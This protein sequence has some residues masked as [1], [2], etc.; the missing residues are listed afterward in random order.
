MDAPPEIEGTAA[1]KKSATASST[2]TAELLPGLRLGHYTVCGLLARGGMAE[3]YLARDAD[4][5]GRL[6]VIKRVLPHLPDAQ[7]PVGMFADEAALSA[8]LHHP[9][10]AEVLE[11][12]DVGGQLFIVLEH[13]RGADALDILQMADKRGTHVPLD[14]A[15]QMVIAVC[16]G[17]HHAHE[18]RGPKGDPMHVIHRDVSPPNVFVTFDGTTKLLDFGLAKSA[19]RATETLGGMA[20]GKLTYMSPEQVMS[21]ALDRRSDIYSL[22]IVLYELTTGTK[23]YD[24]SRGELATVQQ[25]I[26]GP[27][28]SP[29][30]TNPAYPA[31]LEAVVQ[32]ALAKRPDDRFPTAFALAR[33]LEAAAVESGLS[34]SSALIPPF[35]AELY[36]ARIAAAPDALP[37][38]EVVAAAAGGSFQ[39]AVRAPPTLRM[40]PIVDAVPVAPGSRF[41][42][43]IGQIGPGKPRESG[44]SIELGKSGKS[45]RPLR[46]MIF[47]TIAISV[48]IAVVLFVLY[49]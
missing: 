16:A 9:N 3:I 38:K 20:K 6:V 33:A 23:L 29:C 34:L 7:N 19:Y 48:L 40:M 49:R 5:G 32:K 44:G 39:P 4:R 35:L 45:G 24:A 14:V 15:V 47:I 1:A 12:L 22:G 26:D 18:L 37:E 25:I 43:P 10:I 36:P 41:N 27:V 28:P 17:L 21:R 42:R 31:A 13:L 30:A 8:R 11:V 2:S 46:A